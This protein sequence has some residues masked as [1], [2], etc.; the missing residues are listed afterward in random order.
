MATDQDWQGD[1]FQG[2][3]ATA[4]R[5]FAAGKPSLS[6]QIK[7]NVVNAQT[8]T[9][10]VNITEDVPQRAIPRQATVSAEV[11]VEDRDYFATARSSATMS[12]VLMLIVLGFLLG[13]HAI[14]PT[15]ARADIG[16]AGDRAH[17]V[18]HHPG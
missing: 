12:L 3:L 10:R 8:I 13:W 7:L 4:Q 6:R 15:G 9:G 16:G 5:A 1:T 14:N 11:T 2:H 17:P 18:R